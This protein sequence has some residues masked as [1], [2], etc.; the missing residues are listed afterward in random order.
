MT[1]EC[2]GLSS[3]ITDVMRTG[4]YG[5]IWG[6][7]PVRER[8]GAVF[9]ERTGSKRQ[10]AGALHALADDV[11]PCPPSRTRDYG[12]WTAPTSPSRRVVC[13]GTSPGCEHGKRGGG[14]HAE[15]VGIGGDF[16]PEDIGGE[17]LMTPECP[18][19]S[20]QYSDSMRTGIYGEERLFARGW[21]RSFLSGRGQSAR[22]LAHSM[23]WRT[24]ATACT[25]VHTG[26]KGE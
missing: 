7:A 26:R 6:K 5:D 16:V 12:G 8:V 10:R 21:A 22:G 20:S 19:L 18:E 1:L 23:P 13:L 9:L 24:L 4:I 25:C 3:Q 17:M 2:P 15:K 11:P 14:G